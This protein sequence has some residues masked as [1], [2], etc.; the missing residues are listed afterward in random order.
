MSTKG[1][2]KFIKKVLKFQFEMYRYILNDR[3][4]ACELSIVMNKKKSPRKPI[5]PSWG[6][7]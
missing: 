5:R 3:K 1:C 6:K 2:M 4:H 7:L